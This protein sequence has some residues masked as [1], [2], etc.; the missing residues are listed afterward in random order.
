MHCRN[1]SGA[2]SVDFSAVEQEKGETAENRR[3]ADLFLS[4]GLAR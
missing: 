2:Y 1:N 3:T 4:R